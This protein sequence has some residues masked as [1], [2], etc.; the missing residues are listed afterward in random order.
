V[1][2]TGCSTGG[3]GW[4]QAKALQQRGFHVFATAR[5]PSTAVHLA[6]TANIE[7][8]ELDVTV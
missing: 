4:T 3:I 2:I 1:L 6:K 8:V 5:D 7:V